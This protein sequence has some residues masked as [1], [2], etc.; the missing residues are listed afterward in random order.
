MRRFKKSTIVPV[1]VL[2]NHL[3][4]TYWANIRAQNFQTV[5]FLPSS[6]LIRGEAARGFTS[7]PPLAGVYVPVDRKSLGLA[8]IKIVSL[9][10]K[11]NKNKKRERDKRRKSIRRKKIKLSLITYLHSICSFLSP[12][13]RTVRSARRSVFWCTR[14]CQC[15]PWRRWLWWVPART[16]PLSCARSEACMGCAAPVSRSY[17]LKEHDTVRELGIIVDH[18]HDC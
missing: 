1:S 4:R 2:Y 16:A 8:R 18:Q 11:Q 12:R 7:P 13:R 10:R 6:S 14:W 5:F 15:R 3:H 9:L 17:D